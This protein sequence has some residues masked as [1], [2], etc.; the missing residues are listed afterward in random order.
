MRVSGRK[1]RL[2]VGTGFA[3]LMLMVGV[4]SVGATAPGAIGNVNV[5][6]TS[7]N[8][9]A[10]GSSNTT[11]VAANY[12]DAV[13]IT[14]VLSG[15][16]GLGG[17]YNG[18]SYNETGLPSNGNNK[19]SFDVSQFGGCGLT[20]PILQPASYPLWEEQNVA[21]S[22]TV[23]KVPAKNTLVVPPTANPANGTAPGR[24]YVID[25]FR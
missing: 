1:L 4:S 22:G 19:S 17:E 23:I 6:V 7:G 11:Q 20:I 24:T 10:I 21:K 18:C 9:S 3:A 25:T 2:A 14:N 12:R 15:A 13:V 16:G 5:I 8:A